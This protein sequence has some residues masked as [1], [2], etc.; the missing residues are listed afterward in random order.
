MRTL[1]SSPIKV[2]FIIE[3]LNRVNIWQSETYN[4]TAPFILLKAFLVF[5][6]FDFERCLDLCAKY[7][8]STK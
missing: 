7:F 6:I 4:V 8:Y 2:N 1:N 3:N 5:C